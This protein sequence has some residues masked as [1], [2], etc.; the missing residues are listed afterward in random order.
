MSGLNSPVKSAA[1]ANHAATTIMDASGQVLAECS[2]H[3]R[4]GA[5]DAAIAACIV[6]RL[7]AHDDLVSALK[8]LHRVCAS[9][10][11]EHE[12]NRPSEAE[13]IDAMEAAEAALAKAT[14]S[15]S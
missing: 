6:Q 4:H 1:W 13:Y 11:L 5:E 8:E 7:N 3:G 9:M 12:A 14:G 2:G 10:D 15:D